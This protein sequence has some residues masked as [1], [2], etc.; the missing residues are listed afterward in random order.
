M[1]IHPNAFYDCTECMEASKIKLKLILQHRNRCLSSKLPK[2][3][4]PAVTE[5]LNF[6]NK[7]AKEVGQEFKSDY[8]SDE[9]IKKWLDEDFTKKPRMK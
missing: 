5:L 1:K 9:T 6:I 8:E 3:E 7:S 4:E 2:F